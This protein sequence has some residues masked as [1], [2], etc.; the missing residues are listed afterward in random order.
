M[1]SEKPKTPQEELEELLRQAGG[2]AGPDRPTEVKTPKTGMV[3]P[4]A[5]M[6][7]GVLSA[8]KGVDRKWWLIGGLGLVMLIATVFFLVGT[9]GSGDSGIEIIS[10]QSDVSVTVRNRLY[11]NVDNGFK[12]DLRPGNYSLKATRDGYLDINVAV[13]V[14]DKKYSQIVLNWL[15]IPE[16]SEVIAGVDEVRLSSDGT[17]ITYFDKDDFKFKTRVLE[18]EVV[19]ELFRGNFPDVVDIVWSNTQQ[20]A[21]VKISGEPRFT[22]MLDNRGVEGRYLT[23][24]ERPK[25]APS[26]S[27]GQSTWLFD[28]ANKTAAG[29]QPV[30]L[31]ENIRQVAFSEDGSEIVYIYEAADGEYSLVTSLPDGLEWERV[32]KDLPRFNNPELIWSPDQRTVVVIDGSKVYLIDLFNQSVEQTLNDWVIGSDIKFDPSG[33]RLAYF[34]QDGDRVALKKYE[35]IDRIT[36]DVDISLPSGG[37]RMVWMNLSELIVVGEDQSFRK[38]D[39][40]GGQETFIPFTGTMLDSVV[41]E[42]EYSQFG[43]TLMIRSGQKIYYMIV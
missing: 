24:G 31:N 7:E 43:H 14:S 20:A 32:V 40:D 39:V 25:Q 42:L 21:I 18:N 37:V 13:E 17:E 26:L 35:V 28:D 22:N 19:A 30:L 33:N 11:Q 38:I 36:S 27:N 2:Q 23:L 15:A 41:E 34:A 5:R 12:L 16:L 8:A 9:F 6:A 4:V 10:S 29:W 1:E 3:R